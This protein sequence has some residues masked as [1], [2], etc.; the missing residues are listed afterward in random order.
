MSSN[1][2]SK[3]KSLVCDFRD[4]NGIILDKP[5][6]RYIK[7]KIEEDRRPFL[8]QFVDLLM[9]T[10]FITKETKVYIS[11]KYY[12]VEAVYEE[13]KRENPDIKLNTVKAKIYYDKNKI[14]AAFGEDMCANVLE[15]RDV[16]MA[17]Y[18]KKLA[19]VMKKYANINVLDNLIIEL[20]QAEM[21]DTVD[22]AEYETMKQIMLRFSRKSVEDL[23]LL[24]NKQAVGYVNY[25]LT[26][27]LLSE[28]DKE[29]RDELIE[30]L[31]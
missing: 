15:Y 5:A 14:E 1:L 26:S 29:R 17:S 16:D 24:M 18:K 23:K 22:D 11:K 19:D 21:S 20:P 30:L 2:M 13:L 7:T 12:T 25:I 4:D 9:N 3:L 31:G 27:S 10:R 6:G 28:K 8:R